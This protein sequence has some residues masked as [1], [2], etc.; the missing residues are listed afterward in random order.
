MNMLFYIMCA[1]N[2]DWEIATKQ[3]LGVVYSVMEVKC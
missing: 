1:L 2:Q 3:K